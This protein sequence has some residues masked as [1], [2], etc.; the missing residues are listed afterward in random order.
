MTVI[1]NLVATSVLGIPLEKLYG[2]MTYSNVFSIDYKIKSS[3]YLL[4]LFKLTSFYT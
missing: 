3:T 1:Y 2:V 4:I